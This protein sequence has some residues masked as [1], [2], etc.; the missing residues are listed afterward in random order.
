MVKTGKPAKGDAARAA[1]RMTT[2]RMPEPLIKR[3]R[4]YSVE[5]DTTFQ[6]LLIEALEE[7]LKAHRK[8]G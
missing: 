2:I 4:L 3:A 5:T 6:A 7:Y 8:Q 1:W